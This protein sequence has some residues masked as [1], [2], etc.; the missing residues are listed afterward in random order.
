[1]NIQPLHDRVL[2]ERQETESK[3]ASGLYI[4]DTNKEKTNLGKIVAVGQ[5]VRDEKG[6]L[7]PLTVK[8]GDT[9]LFGAYSGTEVKTEGKSYL[10]LREDEILGTVQ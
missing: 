10:V 1:M 3:T 6:N 8:T 4:P 7:I 5:G 2:I 9:V